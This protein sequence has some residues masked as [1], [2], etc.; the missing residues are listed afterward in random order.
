MLEEVYTELNEEEYFIMDYIREDNW[1]DI[2]EEG[3]NK[4]NI[5]DLMWEVY[6]K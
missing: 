5:H 1:R 4:K 2:S 6:V 3:D